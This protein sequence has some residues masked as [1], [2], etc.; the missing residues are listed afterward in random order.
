M[1]DYALNDFTNGWFVGNFEPSIFKTDEF[2]V[3]VKFFQ[4][5]DREPLHRQNIATEITV[6]ISGTV[7][8]NEKEFIRGAIIEVE[9]GEPCEFYS[10][11]DSALICLKFPSIPND[12]IVI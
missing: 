3:S 1:K 9:P 2:E 8:M 6:V 12:K 4:E 11:T 5:G 7:Q 10:V